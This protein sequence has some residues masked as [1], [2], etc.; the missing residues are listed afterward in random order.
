MKDAG[1]KV[2][3]FL[4]PQLLASLDEVV[5]MAPFGHRERKGSV[6]W[7]HLESLQDLILGCFHRHSEPATKAALI[8][9]WKQRISKT[10]TV[11]AESASS[12][13]T[14]TATPCTR[15]STYAFV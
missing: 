8:D 4:S 6:C 7:G 3:P 11:S 1:E 13:A 14:V 12:T 2:L 9:S 15:S 10:N 5:Q